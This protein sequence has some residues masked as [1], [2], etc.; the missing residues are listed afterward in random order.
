MHARKHASKQALQCRGSATDWENTNLQGNVLK[1]Y[2]ALAKTCWQKSQKR[3]SGVP[4]KCPDML[5]HSGIS[6]HPTGPRNVSTAFP[7]GDWGGYD[8]NFRHRTPSL[9]G[10]NARQQQSP[11]NALPRSLRQE[12]TPASIETPQGSR[13]LC[14]SMDRVRDGRSFVFLPPWT[15]MPSHR[16]WCGSCHAEPAGTGAASDPGITSPS[17]QLSKLKQLTTRLAP[18][19]ITFYRQQGGNPITRRRNLLYNS[20]WPSAEIRLLQGKPKQQQARTTNTK[21]PT[22]ANGQGAVYPANRGV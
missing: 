8:A 10:E 18:Q 15:N 17:P 12:S 11:T 19:P 9:F 7:H 20:C 16:R 5:V 2:F 21:S 14:V 4:Q 3:V 22:S 6:I 13:N 1:R